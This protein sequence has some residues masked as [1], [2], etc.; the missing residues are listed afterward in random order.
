MD[1]KSGYP[2]W[3]V[4]NGLPAA[5]PPLRTDLSCDVA[6][7]GAG[8]T[9]ALIA[10][11]LAN[12][13]LDVVVLDKRDVGWGSTAAS[14]AL[15]QYEIDT[16]LVDLARTQ[17]EENAVAAYKACE[18]AIGTLGEVASGL[19]SVGFRRMQS[20]YIASHWY[21][22]ARTRAEGEFRKRHGFSL[23]MLERGELSERFGIRAPVA[24]LTPVAAQVDPYRMTYSLLRRLARGGVRIFDRSEMLSFKPAPRGVELQVQRDV[25]IRCEHLV[26]AAGYEAQKYLPATVAKNRSSYALVTEPPLGGVG[27]LKDTLLWESARPYLYL[28]STSDGRVL[29]GGEDDNVDI[30]IKRDALVRAKSRRLMKKLHRLLPNTPFE[31]GFSWAGTFAETRDGLPFFGPHRKLDKRVHFAMAYGGNGIT[32]SAIGA[33][34]ILAHVLSRK[35]EL[36]RL[37]SFDRVD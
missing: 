36:M 30:P 24:L 13:G 32:Y 5:F 37:F 29:V 10:R 26:I 25:R 23:S 34:I 7:V 1:L 8:I 4:T 19:G 16:E 18:A 11:A 27:I 21:H 2:F 12:A 35:H 22:A 14:T 31:E 17:G 6:V 33:E 3:P 28:R 15:L 9:G 20:L